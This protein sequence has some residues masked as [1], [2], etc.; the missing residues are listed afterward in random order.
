VSSDCRCI[1]QKSGCP[2]SEGR[3]GSNSNLNIEKIA[4]NN[5]GSYQKLEGQKPE[6]NG[7]YFF[8]SKLIVLKE[9]TIK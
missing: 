3:N 8:E 7:S 9:A 5:S 1:K 6:N 4:V 2:Q